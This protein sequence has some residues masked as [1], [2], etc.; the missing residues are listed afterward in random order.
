MVAKGPDAL[1]QNLK[2]VAAEQHFFAD[3]AEQQQDG[4]EKQRWPAQALVRNGLKIGQA[5]HQRKHNYHQRR[6]DAAQQ[7][8]R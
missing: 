6:A 1:H 3:G 2:A 8:E 5:Q 4:N 7:P